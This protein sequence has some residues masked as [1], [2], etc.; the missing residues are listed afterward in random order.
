MFFQVGAK[1]DMWTLTCHLCL[2]ELFAAVIGIET[3]WQR[4]KT[5]IAIWHSVFFFFLKNNVPKEMVSAQLAKAKP[6]Y[7][8][9]MCFSSL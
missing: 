4:P 3:F 2:R 8:S 9:E 7:R 1:C 5:S 6:E